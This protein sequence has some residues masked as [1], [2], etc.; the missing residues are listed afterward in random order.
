MSSR[1]DGRA[2]SIVHRVVAS[3]MT[4][5]RFVWDA[6]LMA[7]VSVWGISCGSDGS[8]TNGVG[9]GTVILTVSG[10]TGPDVGTFEVFDGLGLPIDLPPFAFPAPSAAGVASVTIPGVPVAVYR[11]EYTAPE[12][13]EVVTPAAVG[14]VHFLTADVLPG[15]TRM[16]DFVVAAIVVEPTEGLIFASDFGTALGSGAAALRDTGKSVPWTLSGGSGLE[17]ISSTGL[18]FPTP[19]VLSVTAQ[20][21]NNGYARLFMM[22]LPPLAI[23][24]SRFYRFYFRGM[25]PDGVD[26]NQSH[27]IEDGNAR[28]W[29]FAINHNQGGNGFFTPYIGVSATGNGAQNYR[30]YL[31]AFQ[32]GVT[33]RVEIQIHRLSTTSFNLHVRVYTGAGADPIIT[34][35]NIRNEGGGLSLADT[36]TLFFEEV[37]RIQELWA[38]LNG[39]SG[40]NWHPATLYAYQGGFAVSDSD[41][42]GPYAPGES[43]PP[44]A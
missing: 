5:R 18:G 1:A 20:Q 10:L 24:N 27:P 31:P 2:E 34:D 8:P 12:G 32:K 29:M 13:H 35:A 11:L 4:R 7:A 23:G 25:F 17:V 14:G 37:G 9:T 21:A 33:Y 40:S 19:N 43:V 3:E 6:S 38:G 15:T 41:W 16:L 28:N 42:C 36:P 22:D 30:W 44:P 26:D 39:L